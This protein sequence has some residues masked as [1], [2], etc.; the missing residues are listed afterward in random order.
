MQI[1]NFPLPPPFTNNLGYCSKLPFLFSTKE[2][3]IT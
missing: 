3:S 2:L 1:R